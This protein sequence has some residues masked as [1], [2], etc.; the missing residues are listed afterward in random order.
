MKRILTLLVL[1]LLVSSCED[2]AEWDLTKGSKDFIVV[3]GIITNELKVQSISLSEPV[4]TINQRPNPV[5]GATILVSSDSA[6]YSFHEDTSNPGIYLSDKEFKGINN[7]TYSLL[8]TSN[9]KVFSAKAILASPNVIRYFVK[10]QKSESGEKYHITWV[11]D[12]YN[13]VNPA[14][15]EVLLDWSAVPGYENKNPDSC[16]FR[17]FY[18]ALPTL[19][20]SEIFA[21]AMEKI[22]FPSGTMI[23]ERKYSITPDHAA[24][25]RALLLETSWQGG[26]FN[27]AAA[28]VPTNMSDG[29]L[30]YFGACGVTEMQ[31]TAK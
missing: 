6:V 5:S 13:A 9:G 8:I 17:L 14:I 20:V 30:G 19:D 11:A 1:F 27:T 24:F 16:K 3:D 28:N 29:A 23:T 10:Y 26:F 15:Y 18:Y 4:D 31:E 25:L 12:P 21:P 7:K 22:T 2:K